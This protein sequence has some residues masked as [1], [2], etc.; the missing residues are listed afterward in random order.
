MATSYI[1]R[2]EKVRKRKPNKDSILQKTSVLLNDIVPGSL[3]FT[4]TGNDDNIDV[5]KTVAVVD[6]A[7]GQAPLHEGELL[8]IKQSTGN[9]VVEPNP[10]IQSMFGD[11]LEPMQQMNN[12]Q[13]LNDA[14]PPSQ[15]VMLG[16]PAGFMIGTGSEGIPLPEED[17]YDA[18]DY[19]SIDGSSSMNVNS[20]SPVDTTDYYSNNSTTTNS[21][22]LDIPEYKPEPL[23]EY[24]PEVI[25]ETQPT[26]DQTKIGGTTN[27]MIQPASSTKSRVFGGDDTLTEGNKYI[28]SGGTEGT[29][30]PT[31]PIDDTQGTIGTPISKGASQDVIDNQQ[32]DTLGIYSIDDFMKSGGV[33]ETKYSG[34]GPMGG[35]TQYKKDLLAGKINPDGTPI[36]TTDSTTYGPWGPNG[37]TGNVIAG[38]VGSMDTADPAVVAKHNAQIQAKKD[39]DAKKIAEAKGQTSW[40]LLK[41][42]DQTTTNTPKEFIQ[43]LASGDSEVY[44]DLE[45]RTMND[46]AATNRENIM[47]G[48]QNAAAMEG[49]GAQGGKIQNL[50]AELISNANAARADAMG[51]LGA[52]EQDQMLKA[53]ELLLKTDAADRELNDALLNNRLSDMLD[54]GYSM[55]EIYADPEIQRISNI[56]YGDTYDYDT[57]KSEIDKR[58]DFVVSQ[59]FDTYQGNTI[60]LI[61]SLNNKGYTVDDALTNTKLLNNAAKE[62]GY[63]DSYDTLSPDDKTKVND[64]ISNLYGLSGQS[65][66]EKFYDYASTELFADL[67]LED[68]PGF[69][70]D[71]KD[72]FLKAVSDGAIQKNADTGLWEVVDNTYAWPWTDPDKKFGNYVGF[73]GEELLYGDNGQV[74][75][76]DKDGNQTDWNTTTTETANTKGETITW[77][78]DYITAE[79]PDS[80]YADTGLTNQEINKYWK[81]EPNKDKYYGD[82]GILSPQEF[83][84]FIEDKVI[85]KGVTSGDWMGETGNATTDWDS[86]KQFDEDTGSTWTDMEDEVI[87]PDNNSSFTG[88][89]VPKTASEQNLVVSGFG[90]DAATITPADNLS[91]EDQFGVWGTDGKFHVIDQASP[92]MQRIWSQMSIAY[93]DGEPLSM[94]QFSQLWG[95][96]SQWVADDKGNIVNATADQSQLQHYQDL[97]LM[98]EDG[99]IITT[100]DNTIMSSGNPELIMGAANLG[101]VQTTNHDHE[102][103]INVSGN[104]WSRRS[105]AGDFYNAC[106]GKVCYSDDGRPYTTTG[107]WNVDDDNTWDEPKANDN[108]RVGYTWLDTGETGSS[109]FY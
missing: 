83:N 100:D 74:M 44:N 29:F 56:L 61:D 45:N 25:Q 57:F 39:A 84:K 17:K 32:L 43:D 88:A 94:D 26:I 62:L 85:N 95:D 42:N 102:S 81:N 53:N 6:T 12:Q 76:V 37:N 48:L 47:F 4:G 92:E 79:Y 31:E 108:F 3:M 82:D 27:V 59:G 89:S 69:K 19:N 99:T 109:L 14:T 1:N 93:N 68:T 70:Q 28:K 7:G 34:L 20:P 15:N 55:A 21:S 107:K 87:D 97:G 38:G 71:M 65:N 23:P 2:I 33:F 8:G 54:A 86:I 18:T 67:G 9:L 49:L 78:S 77:D 13:Y 60:S 91:T 40:E 24:K 73:N 66:F 50:N 5:T 35:Y 103:S 96:G 36:T 64:Y 104:R 90:T 10:M 101:L 105:A 98:A 58:S 80:E 52:N 41:Q 51:N 16:M 75:V 22:M 11:Q 72:V 63:P 30:A 46:I 106:N